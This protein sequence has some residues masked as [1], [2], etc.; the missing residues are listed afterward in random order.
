MPK[1]KALIH[2]PRVRPPMKKSFT[3]RVRRMDSH[4]TQSMISTY[5]TTIAI[6]TNGDMGGDSTAAPPTPGLPARSD[7][8]GHAGP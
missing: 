8:P 3:S 7:V 5:A 2:G 1:A 4:P 6:E